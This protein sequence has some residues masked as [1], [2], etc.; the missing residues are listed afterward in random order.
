M[1]FTIRRRVPAR[2]WLPV[3]TAFF[4]ALTISAA[5]RPAYSQSLSGYD[6]DRGLAM[7]DAVKS[8]VRKNYYDPAFRGMDLD[9]RFKAAE[10]KIKQE[11]TSL[12]HVLAIIAQALLDLNDSH[13]FFIPPSKVSRTDY[14]WQMQMVGERCFVTAVK[15]KSDADAKGLKVGDEVLAVDG[16][17]PTRDDLWKIKYLYYALRPR[18][19]MRLVIRKP[20]GKE[21]Q[22]DVMAKVQSG[23]QLMDLTAGQDIWTL[24]RE[25]EVED[26]LHRHRYIEAGDELLIWKMPQF[27]LPDAGVDEMMSK[28]RKRKSLIL[29]LRGNGGGYEDTLKR[30]AGYFFDRDVKIAELKGRKELKPLVAVTRGDKVFKGKLVVLIDSESGSAAEMFARVVQLEKRGTVIGDRSAGAVMRSR[31]YEHQ[32]GIDVVSFYAVSVTEADAVMS[33]GKSLER[34]GVTPDEVLLPT[35]EEMAGN[36]D[37]VLARAAAVVGVPLSPEKAGEMFPV[38]WRK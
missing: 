34:T 22:V 11:A 21:S 25:S 5:L 1:K 8:D 17:V 4:L 18:A 36:R 35:A 20:D 13:T 3:P 26:R 31:A 27:D 24:I 19:G 9:A 10:Q 16:F 7:L 29:D 33:D 32:L 6:R 37:P 28:A 2:A 15:P 12:G 30:L 38:E 14:G 23:K